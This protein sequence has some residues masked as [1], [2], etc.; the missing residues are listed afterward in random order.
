MTRLKYLIIIYCFHLILAH[1]F[2]CQIYITRLVDFLILFVAY[3][4]FNT[5]QDVFQVL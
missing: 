1:G 4:Y 5:F 2:L 3:R